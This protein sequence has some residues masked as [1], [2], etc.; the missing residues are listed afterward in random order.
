[1][2]LSRSVH[3]T[4]ICTAVYYK[5][6]TTITNYLVRRFGLK[7]KATHGTP[8]IPLIYRQAPHSNPSSFTRV[9]KNVKMA[10][11]WGMLVLATS[12]LLSSARWVI[13]DW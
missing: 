7:I 5:Y 6:H 8:T 10:K 13:L 11:V 4:N 9:L 1:M 3:T 2:E 12:A